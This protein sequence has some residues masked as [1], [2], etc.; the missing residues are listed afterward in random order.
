MIKSKKN[1]ILKQNNSTFSKTSNVSEDK[2]F[3]GLNNSNKKNLKKTNSNNKSNRDSPLLVSQFNYLKLKENSLFNFEY[4]KNFF[5]KEI[6]CSILSNLK[7][8]FSFL[9]CFTL[10]EDSPANS[11]ELQKTLENV[12]LNIENCNSINLSID[13]CLF[14]IFFKNILRENNHDLL[15]GNNINNN[16]NNNKKV[17]GSIVKYYSPILS[18]N[19]EIFLFNFEFNFDILFPFLD[20]NSKEFFYLLNIEAGTTFKKKDD[21]KNLIINQQTNKKLNILTIP[22]IETLLNEKEENLF[23]KI[24]NYENFM[25]NLYNINYNSFSIS[26]PLNNK[27]Y[28]MFIDYKTF[29]LISKKFLSE[30]EFTEDDNYN[31][32]HSLPIY[33]SKNGFN[34]LYSSEIICEYKRHLITFEQ[35]MNNYIEKTQDDFKSFFDLKNFVFD[36]QT[37]GNC[38]FFKKII[39]LMRIIGKIFMIFF[40]S[41]ST[42]FLYCVFYEGFKTKY[43]TKEP[44]CFSVA[45]LVLIVIILFYGFLIENK[46][47]HDKKFFNDIQLSNSYNFMGMFLFYFSGLFYLFCFIISILAV[48]YIDKNNP[49]SPYKINKI[50]CALTI[51]IN[52]IFAIIPLLLYI[53]SFGQKIIQSFLYLILHSAGYNNMFNNIAIVTAFYNKNSHPFFLLFYIVFNSLMLCFGYLLN[54][55]K[56]RC[57]FVLTISII[58]TIYNCLKMIFIITNIFNNDS[59]EEEEEEKEKNKKKIANKKIN[60]K[61]EEESN[62]NNENEE[63]E[64]EEE[65]EEEESNKNKKKNQKK[66]NSNNNN[67]N[68]EE[69]EEDYNYSKENKKENGKKN[70]SRKS[71]GKKNFNEDDNEEEEDNNNKNDDENDNNNNNN[72]D[73][74][75]NENESEK[76]ETIQKENEENNDENNNEENE[77][78]S[79][80]E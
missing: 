72:D 57:N 19:I 78:N 14:M 47:N 52:F 77:K 17:F 80:D 71:N 8:S 69:E 1:E 11:V 33:L 25:Y 59:E 4:S 65:E 20:K 61:K 37:K 6:N 10:D 46:K 3:S 12:I 45:N 74:N 79:E 31:N 48:H 44:F 49:K 2:T 32:R 66:S 67:E 39:C 54:T 28:L 50:A 30:N 51:I 53:K 75:N 21:L 22:K 42:M 23:S 58:F 7:N 73:D 13:R 29:S 9:I 55:R 5:N 27:I 41:F 18:E 16:N 70:D 38:M 35:M 26:I 36:C 76:K 43:K 68:E 56:S 62:K 40:P 24:E 63:E 60:K 64:D 34:V 15:F